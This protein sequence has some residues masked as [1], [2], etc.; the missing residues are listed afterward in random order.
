MTDENNVIA[1]CAACKQCSKVLAFHSRNVV[2]YEDTQEAPGAQ[3]LE[4]RLRTTVQ[5]QKTKKPV[6]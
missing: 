5:E 6:L 1:G 2:T 3:L 4:W